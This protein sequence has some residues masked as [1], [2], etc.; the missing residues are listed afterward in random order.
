MKK[1]FEMSMVGELNY[2]LGLQVKQWKDEIFISQEKYAE[3]LVKRFGLDS[4]KHASTPMSSLVKLS[5][6]LAGVEVDPT[7]YK[8][9]IGSL[10][11]LTASRL[12]IAF[13]VGVCAHFQAAPKESHMTAVK[14]I[15]RYVNG[16]S[17]CGI[18]YSRDSN[19]YLF[20]Y[21][22]AD[23][24][25]CVNDRKSTSGGYFYLE[26]NLVSWMSKKQNSVSLSMA[27]A[28]YIAVESC[29]AQLLWMKKLLHDYGIS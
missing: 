20:E 11:Y 29:Y 1:E 26:N 10:L 4:K 14:R 2:F 17:D 21:S 28:W 15:I 13:S 9:M 12:D 23:W 22:D 24:I 19:D 27:K 3:N 25:R 7:L 5:S 16:T 18:W 8:S 6:D